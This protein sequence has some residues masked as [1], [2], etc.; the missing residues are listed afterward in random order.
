MSEV[1]SWRKWHFEFLKAVSTSQD[2]LAAATETLTGLALT[3]GSILAGAQQARRQG[4]I[5]R[6]PH[7]WLGPLFPTV[8]AQLVGLGHPLWAASSSG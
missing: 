3:R 4:R 8:P 7:Q 2:A 1:A 5:P 6:Q